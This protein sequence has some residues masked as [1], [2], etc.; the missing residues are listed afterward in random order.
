MAQP[1]ET[2]PDFSERDQKALPLPGVLT[3][4]W[5]FLLEVMG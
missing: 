5:A 2:L 1:I 3:D 4:R